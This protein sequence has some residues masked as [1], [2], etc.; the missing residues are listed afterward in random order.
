MM[1][2]H[3]SFPTEMENTRD[4]GVIADMQ[5]GYETLTGLEPSIW[6]IRIVDGP[7]HS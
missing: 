2:T 6:L 1:N 4:L 7:P 5:C 3:C